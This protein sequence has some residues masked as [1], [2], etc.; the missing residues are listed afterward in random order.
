VA[1]L[2]ILATAAACGDRPAPDSPPNV[3]TDEV[4]TDPAL[5]ADYT[6]PAPDERDSA[7]NEGNAVAVDEGNATN[8]VDYAATSDV[9]EALREVQRP[10]VALPI[11]PS[12]Q[13]MTTPLGTPWP[14]SASY[15]SGFDYLRF[16]GLSTVT[17]DNSGN[18]EN[19][20]VKLVALDGGPTPV[21]HVFIPGYGQFTMGSLSPG[22]YDVRYQVLSDGGLYKTESFLATQ[23]SNEYSI[24][25][26]TLFTVPG[27]NMQTRR[28]S[29]WTE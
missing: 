9:D 10:V 8:T 18:S 26:L 7:S 5:M 23:T 19:V 13:V 4:L 14:A 20:F 3:A 28:I 21:R 12:R 6:D 27:G 17:V 16:D 15:L 1:G 11:R 25:R 24:F 22:R 29:S 2:A